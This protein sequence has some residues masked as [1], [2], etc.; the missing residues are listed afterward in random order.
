MNAVIKI[1]R[2]VELPISSRSSKYPY[3]E[4]EVNDSFVVP[5]LSLQVVCN[6]NYRANQK[7]QRKF[8]ARKCDG[9]VRVW[10]VS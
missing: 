8:V 4:L 7:L 2:D 10:R 1:D 3:A 5:N 6:M 9:G